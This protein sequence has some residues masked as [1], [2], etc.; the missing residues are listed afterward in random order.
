MQGS[1]PKGKN[2]GSIGRSHRVGEENGK[3]L[4]SR[5]FKAREEEKLLP[6]DHPDRTSIHQSPR[7]SQEQWGRICRMKFLD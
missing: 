6:S 4:L 3:G 1:S 2:A 5:H 7:T